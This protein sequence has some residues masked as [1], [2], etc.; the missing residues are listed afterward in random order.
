MIPSNPPGNFS[1]VDFGN[2]VRGLAPGL[3]L[4]GRF[5]LL[6]MLGRGGMGV[7]W[8]A[9]DEPLE[10]QV[11]LKFLPEIVAHDRQALRDLKREVLKSRSL[12][13]DHI[14]RVHDFVTDGQVAAISMEPIDGGTLTDLRLDQPNEIFEPEHIEKWVE[15]L[16]SALGY[17]H[18]KARLVHRDLKP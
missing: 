4:F 18:E 7:V 6:R 8:L 5:T 13:S 2:T 15:Q 14:V 11:A 16:C 9:R 10:C 12:N 3:K 1:D 17:A